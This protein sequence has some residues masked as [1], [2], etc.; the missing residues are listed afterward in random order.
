MAENYNATGYN[1]LVKIV[2]S[3]W[4]S[5]LAIAKGTL[6]DLDTPEFKAFKTAQDRADRYYDE[7]QKV[8]K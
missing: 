4:Q 2:E 5:F 6:K 7:W 8:I 1:N 3:Y